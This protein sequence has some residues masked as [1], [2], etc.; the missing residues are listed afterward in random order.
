M[1][2]TLAN[3]RYLYYLCA[4]PRNVF[5][6]PRERTIVIVESAF[7][8]TPVRESLARVLFTQLEAFS[9]L[10]VPAHLVAVST[11]AVDTAVVIDIG[12]DEATVLPVYSGIQVL[13]AFQAQPNAAHAVHS[14]LRRRLCET[15]VS[16]ALLTDEVIEDITVRTCF[17]PSMQMMADL[18]S[19]NRKPCPDVEYPV[20][21]GEVIVVPGL[22]REQVYDVLFVHDNE[23]SAL[24]YQVLDA[25]LA[26]P[27]DMRRQLAENLHVIGGTA[28]ALGLLARLQEELQALVEQPLYAKRLFVDEFKFHVSPLRANFVSWLGGALYGATELAQTRSLTRDA[29]TKAGCLPD[30]VAVEDVMR[31]AGSK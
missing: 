25:I 23:R 19:E 18:Q 13:K 14:E 24:P 9:V 16:A 12:Y 3:L 28:M 27:I 10:F 17:V 2:Q 22:V 20:S 15:G 6:H 30:W 5:V 11:L 4:P 29:Y 31:S 21:G 7:C 26:C 8:P 1:L